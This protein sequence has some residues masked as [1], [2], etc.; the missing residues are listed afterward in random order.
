MLLPCTVICVDGYV[1]TCHNVCT[2]V[3]DVSVIKATAN[4]QNQKTSFSASEHQT[5]G[6][7]TTSDGKSVKSLTTY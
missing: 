4:T 5:L 3:Y 7:D 1:Y 2:D 6:S